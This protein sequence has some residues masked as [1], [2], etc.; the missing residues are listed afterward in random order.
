MIHVGYTGTQ[1]GMTN[2]QIRTLADELA[3]RDTGEE[4]VTGHHGDCIGGDTQFHA[5]IQGLHWEVTIHPGLT[6]L[7]RGW[8][9]GHTTR[10]PKDNLLRNHDIVDETTMLYAAPNTAVMAIRSGTCATIRY[11]VKQGKDVL[12]ILPDG[13]TRSGKEF[14]S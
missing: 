5:L 2:A 13:T 1:Y 7:K 6:T 9:E 4:L 14:M 12:V 11:A 8:N 10:E 3:F